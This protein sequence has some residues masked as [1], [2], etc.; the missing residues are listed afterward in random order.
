[1]FVDVPEPATRAEDDPMNLAYVPSAPTRASVA[2]DFVTSA[3]NVFGGVWKA[4][5]GGDLR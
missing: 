4:G 2:F 3:A 5:A 1:M